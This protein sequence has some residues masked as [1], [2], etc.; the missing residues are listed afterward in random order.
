MAVLQSRLNQL[1]MAR[2][3][4]VNAEHTQSLSEIGWGTQIR[5]YILHVSSLFCFLSFFL[6]KITIFWVP[7]S[8][9]NLTTITKFEKE[10]VAL[11][12]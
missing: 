12:K 4:Q 9:D 2:Q 7:S 10:T 5:S 3:A 6:L 11:S 1:E 8:K